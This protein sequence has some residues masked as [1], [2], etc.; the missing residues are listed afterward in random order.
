MG[1]HLLRDHLQRVACDQIG[2]GS[3]F[4]QGSI[5]P[6]ACDRIGDGSP[7]A[8][9][10]PALVAHGW[11]QSLLVAGFWMKAVIRYLQDLE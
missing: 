7:F 3:P 9:E 8:Q 10:P 11:G 4:A 5:A 2:D 6:V 1:H